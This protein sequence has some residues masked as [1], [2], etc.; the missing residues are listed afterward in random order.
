MPDSGVNMSCLEVLIN[1]NI[2]KKFQYLSVEA[3]SICIATL[4]PSS[5]RRISLQSRCHALE[6]ISLFSG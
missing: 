2:L 5:E 1:W 3:E 6:I 4:L